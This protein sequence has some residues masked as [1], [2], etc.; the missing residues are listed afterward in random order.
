MKKILLTVWL[1]IYSG[2]ALASNWECINRNGFPPTCNTWRWQ[3][4]SGWLVSTD[5]GDDHI[6]VT[7]VPDENHNWRV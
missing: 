4:P 2:L 5:N 7:F 6:S 3:V 1:L